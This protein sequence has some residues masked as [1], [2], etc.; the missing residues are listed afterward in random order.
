[1]VQLPPGV[2]Q[3]Q[4]HAAGSGRTCRLMQQQ[5][6]L[7]QQQQQQQQLLQQAQQAQNQFLMPPG[8]QPQPHWPVATSVRHRRRT[9]T[10]RLCL[11]RRQR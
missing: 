4:P 2:A 3:Q 11:A 8:T 1:L 7:Q 9:T 5:Q 6:Q 10:A